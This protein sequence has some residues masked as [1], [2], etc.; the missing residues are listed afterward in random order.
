MQAPTFPQILIFQNPPYNGGMSAKIHSQKGE[1]STVGERIALAR[2]RKGMTQKELAEIM[3]VT[4]QSI[5]SW[6]RSIPSIGSNVLIQLT[7]ILGVS[8]DELLGLSDLTTKD[9]VNGR[10]WKV[11]ASVSKLSR[12]EKQKVLDVV[13]GFLSSKQ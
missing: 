13:E 4:Q 3:G 2:K 7:T 9:S 8:A 11:F 10:A 6:E 5:A 12:T 1:R